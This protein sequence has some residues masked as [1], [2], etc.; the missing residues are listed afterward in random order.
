MNSFTI[1][2]ILVVLSVVSAKHWS[3]DEKEFFH[4]WKKEHNKSYK[5]HVEEQEAMKNV[6]EHKSK[7]DEHNKL[8]E[9][10][11]KKYKMKLWEHCDLSSD[12]MHKHLTGLAVPE[13]YDEEED[14]SKRAAANYPHY[15]PGPASIDWRKRGLV[16][17]VENQKQCGSCYT[18]STAAVIN[19][20]M[21]KKKISN[22][23]ASP[24]VLVDCAPNNPGGKYYFE[25][26]V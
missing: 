4:A 25:E 17:I 10:G 21:R 6:L 16:T 19:S 5:S 14:R 15:P 2:A 7:V 9:A 8:Y 11:E 12:D 13:G 22:G 20:L 3:K 24:Q 23:L 1:L 26:L 18:F